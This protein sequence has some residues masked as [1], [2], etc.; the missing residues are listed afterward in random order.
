M[1]PTLFA[2]TGGEQEHSVVRD[3]SIKESGKAP[4]YRI[5]AVSSLTGLPANTIRTWERR[6]N[7]VE[8]QRTDGGMRL[9]SQEDVVR[10]QLIRALCECNEN[11]G[12]IAALTTPQLRVRLAIHTAAAENAETSE[13]TES[14]SVR[15]AVLHTTMLEQLRASRQDMAGM[16]LVYAANAISS[17]VDEVEA[18]DGDVEPIDVLVIDLAALGEDP[19][20]ALE[21]ARDAVNA[22]IALVVY[23][24]T[25]RSILAKLARAG[26]RLLRGPVRVS[27]LRQSIEDQLAFDRVVSR[28][29]PLRVPELGPIAAAPPRRF[30]DEQLARLR[31]IRSEVECE[32]PNHLASLVTALTS[33]EEYSRHC[34]NKNEQDAALHASLTLGTARARDLIERLLEL[35]C[36][37]EELDI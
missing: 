27:A 22:R 8:P 9:Y 2:E 24:F 16:T 1:V 29:K 20:S 33:F 28:K 30:S 7:V 6:Y 4:Q 14:G 19:V 5:S 23:T 31:E 36:Q 11:I 13:V 25:T 12:A 18:A 3:T 10:L 32:C 26:A 35:V 15:L 34:K 37:Q 21:Q 17:L